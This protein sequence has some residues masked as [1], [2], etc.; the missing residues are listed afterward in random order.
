MAYIL[1]VEDNPGDI[2]MTREA[3]AKFP[4]TKLDVVEDGDEAIKYLS[5]QSD[6]PEQSAPDFILL[7][8]NLPG[9]SG[10]EVLAFIKSTEALKRI[11]TIILSS[12]TNTQEIREL[13]AMHANC[14]VA[15]PIEAD[16]FFSIISNIHT[17]WSRTAQLA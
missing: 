2:E 10:K 4:E 5:T 7:D 14:Y 11:P 13:Y 8:L 17:Y 16:N 12:S 15:K 6:G 1:L 3:L 9:S